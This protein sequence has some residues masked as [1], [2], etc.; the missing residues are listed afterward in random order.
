M[1]RP[2]QYST[3]QRVEQ[4]NTVKNAGLSRAD[5]RD[6][7]KQ[8][9]KAERK[10][11][12]AQALREERKAKID[13]ER[14]AKAL[15]Q[16]KAEAAKRLE[17]EKKKKA[18]RNKNRRERIPV[19]KFKRNIINRLSNREFLE[20]DLTKLPAITISD[21]LKE[22][23][24]HTNNGKW[25]IEILKKDTE[26]D[27][28]VRQHYTINDNTRNRLFDLIMNDLVIT[29]EMKESDEKFSVEV[30]DADTINLIPLEPTTKNK[31]YIGAFFKYNNLTTFDLSRYGIYKTNNPE[32]YN[33]TCL[34]VALR[35]GGLH[36][37]KIESIK[38]MVKNRIIPKCDI[39]KICDLVKIQI[40][41]KTE[42][43]KN[44]CIFGKQ[45][46]EKYVI[47]LLDDHYFLVEPTNITAYSI[48][49]YEEVKDIENFNE[50]YTHYTTKKGKSYEKSKTRGI[51]SFQVVQELL[52]KSTLLQKITME[53]QLIASTQ[54]YSMID[55]QVITNLEYNEENCVRPVKGT[56]EK[57]EE[58]EEKEQIPFQNVFFD[59]EA[60][61]TSRHKPYLC[62]TYDGKT[63]RE[64]IGEKCGLYM[65]NSLKKDTRLIAHN[66]TYD[67]RFIIE[68]LNNIQE[69][70]KGTRLISASG[71]FKGFKIQVKDSYH[72]ISMGLSKFP[73]TFKL[74]FHKEV[75]PYSLYT[76][77]NIKKRFVSIE[78]A[79]QLVE[80]NDREQFLE[81][82]EKWNCKKEDTYDIIEYSSQYC[83]LDCKILHDGY[84]LFRKWIL[85]AFFIDVDNILTI[86]SLAHRYFV[87]EGCYDG[88]MELGGIPQMFIQGCVVGGRVMCAENIKQII[89]KIVNDFDAVSL[90]ASAMD[91]MPGFL[92]G[93]PK[94][95]QNLSYDWIQQQDGY[96]IDIKITN[97][98]KER[99]FPLM[100]YKKENFV[101]EFT[102][103]MVGK[104]IRVDKTTLEDLIT[105]QNVKFEIL[106]G[107][108]F[109]EGFNTEINRVIKYIFNQRLIKKKAENPAEIIYKLIMNS[110]YGKSIMKPVETESRFFDTYKNDDDFKT[111]LS[112][113]YNWITSCTKFGKK[114]K[115]NTV[116]TLI[117]HYNIAQVGVC[118]LSMSKRIM[119]EVMCLAEDSSI[120]IYYQDTDSMHLQNK[121]IE[122]L[123]M[124]YKKKYQRDL[125]GKNMGQFH[126][127]FE[128]EGCKNVVATKSIFLG[129]KCYIDQLEGIDESGNKK[130]GFHIRMKGIPEKCIQY[131]VNNNKKYKTPMDLYTD[132]FKGN[133][134]RFDLTNGGQKANFKF[135]KDYT[136]DTIQTGFFD[137]V[138]KF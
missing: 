50:I 65:L 38:L 73:K 63:H 81:N 89:E 30:R 98:G 100:S 97:V 52:K 105:F 21:L 18:E 26:G 1:N 138:I 29:Q 72:L 66:C 94:V 75:M 90:Y 91:R 27:N 113:N 116:K 85:E 92:K 9:N 37:S 88:V 3:P 77:E 120:D 31:V 79:L 64:F 115:V 24:T 112:R 87:Q 45:Y 6:V 59:F 127:D 44:K 11:R 41:Y 46:D 25:L 101:R 4:Y 106:R 104:I 135:N 32:N 93:S 125:I 35:N 34:I 111:Y 19:R 15:A 10:Y 17:E 128:L 40:E 82:I 117:E 109:N 22:I 12:R 2:L 134:V 78:E 137:R 107:Y 49:N 96:F 61:S 118:I 108:Y 43:T 114:I 60:D 132:L 71:S 14:Q 80:E 5:Y 74:S 16:Y 57:K 47:G 33:D 121:D 13:Q 23:I 7:I 68:Y 76:K 84:N 129:K 51:S 126:S 39:S 8:L 42:N 36:E 130:I 119:N 53:D 110:G 122:T 86:A 20:I 62:R 133:P 67:F 131:V 69:L 123:A 103:D 136:I 28:R 102:N 48:Q 56:V 58:E 124:N 70:A 54:F 83:L 95:I 55:S 99:R